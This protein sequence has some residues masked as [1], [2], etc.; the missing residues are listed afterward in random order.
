MFASAPQND[1]RQ[2]VRDASDIAAVVGEHLSLKA[3][4]RE[5]VGLCPFHDDRNPSMCVV[6]TKQIFHCFV[7]G[8]G[9]DVFSFIQ[10]YH[11]MD[12]REALEF[13]AERGNIELSKFSPSN[14]SGDAPP[15]GVGRKEIIAANEA[16]R[17]YFRTILNHPEHGEIARELIEQRGISAEMVDRFQIGASADRWDGL[18]MTIDKMKL[19][20]EA[21]ADAGLLKQR[22]TGGEYDALRNRLIFPI[23][24]QIG[25]VI[26]FGGRK[27][28]DED[29]PKYLNSP[30]TS[31]FRKSTTLYGLNH[32]ARAI[33]K[34]RTAVIVEGY[35][36]VIACHQ[37]GIEHVVGTL[38]T[39]LTS[40]HA[41]VL[42]RLCDTVVLLFDGDEAGQRAADRAL[43]VLFSETIDIKVAALSGYTDAKDPDELLARD[44]G[45]E[46]FER[47]IDGAEDLLKWHFDRLRRSLS[48]AGPARMTQA[49]EDELGKLSEL[50]IANLSPIRRRLVIRQIANA[51][52]IEES[53]VVNALRA[54]R[55]G[56]R[57]RFSEPGIEEHP[58]HET[59]WKPDA[60][61]RLLGCLLCDG[62][63]WISMSSEERD[64]LS[65]GLFSSP[66]SRMVAQA[67]LDSVED[68]TGSELHAVLAVLSEGE[69]N[70]T[71]VAPRATT[72]HQMVSRE[73]EGEN[74]RVRR[75]FREC[76]N[77]SAMLTMN[78][79]RAE[80]HDTDLEM[81][82]TDR[83]RAFIERQREVRNR[84]GKGGKARLVDE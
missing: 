67:M 45:A 52:G 5:Y 64:L 10:K 50:G 70:E 1:D 74:E 49:I 18:S 56:P 34:R 75:M 79:D 78:H 16:A 27:I 48:D 54:G 72:L 62:Q 7:C 12:F 58:D 33:K 20:R 35:T 15:S 84:F 46:I 8:A 26:A 44:D 13:L 11:S 68:G 69:D 17:N 76:V 38:G 31:V 4:G 80:S 30:E 22:E 14:A 24:D 39:A 25:R 59:G 37:A 81:D 53:I 43:G 73:T 61:E 6:P 28:N 77:A 29:E 32:A 47:V 51:S 55:N 2:R 41:T 57:Q 60:R 71:D 83:L 82:E 40:G 63:L 21:F 9:G 19:N 23:H 36:D 65:A 42:R 66:M 3:K